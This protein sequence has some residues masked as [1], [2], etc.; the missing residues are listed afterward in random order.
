V[1]NVLFAAA[2]LDYNMARTR[3]TETA[4]KSPTVINPSTVR[5]E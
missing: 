4:V 3:Y 5:L 2:G 1:N